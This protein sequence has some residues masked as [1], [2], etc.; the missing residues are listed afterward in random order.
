MEIVED[1]QNKELI[2]D[3]CGSE[4]TGCQAENRGQAKAMSI[5]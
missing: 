4:I 3:N 5:L 1:R 2:D